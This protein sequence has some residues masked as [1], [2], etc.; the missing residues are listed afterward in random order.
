M[1]QDKYT[2]Q[3]RIPSIVGLSI[4]QI[5]SSLYTIPSIQIVIQSVSRMKPKRLY[6][7]SLRLQKDIQL[8]CESGIL[9]SM[10]IEAQLNYTQT[11][12]H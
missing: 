1:G 12:E 10:Y 8:P 5:C 2:I 7:Y 6:F 4:Q 11:F 3:I 9:L